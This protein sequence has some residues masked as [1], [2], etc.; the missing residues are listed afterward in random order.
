MKIPSIEQIHR[1]QHASIWDTEKDYKE[2]L[3]E[4]PNLPTKY[5]L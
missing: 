2:Y 4:E 5:V 1:E 3:K